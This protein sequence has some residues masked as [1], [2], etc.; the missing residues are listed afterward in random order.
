MEADPTYGASVYGATKAA[1]ER[2]SQGL[3]ME[4][5]Q[6]KISVNVLAPHVPIWSEGGA[7]FRQLSGS[8]NYSGWRMSGEIMGDAAVVICRQEPG[9]HTGNIL[10]DELMMRDEGGLGDEVMRRYPVEA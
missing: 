3:A 5:S 8:E 9:L 6:D 10:Y 7:Y 1:L 2:F 4:V